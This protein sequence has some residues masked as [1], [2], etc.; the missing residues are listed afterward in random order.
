M[1]Q[2]T[3]SSEYCLDVLE[4]Y[5][6]WAEIL[7]RTLQLLRRRLVKFPLLLRFR[8]FTAPPPPVLSSPLTQP[9]VVT[10]YG[11]SLIDAGAR[12]RA[13]EVSPAS[14][15]LHCSYKYLR[16]GQHF[17]LFLSFFSLLHPLL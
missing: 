15:K 9:T 3:V 10:I 13:K 2:V 7:N 4:R 5:V 12:V 11:G 1:K 16:L 14:A 17:S 8:G 6:R